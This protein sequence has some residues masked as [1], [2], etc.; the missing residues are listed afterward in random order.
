MTHQRH[1]SH[2]LS[3]TLLP[4]LLLTCLLLISIAC[5][6]PTQME[7]PTPV[8]SATATP[9]TVYDMKVE[10]L[11]RC[12]QH[13][14]KMHATFVASVQKVAPESP[15]LAMYIV[16]DADAFKRLFSFEEASTGLKESLEK[17]Y[18]ICTK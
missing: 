4:F 17:A 3:L 5:V 11:F 8:P 12:L 1:P 13:N 14:T 9:A 10:V 6:Q 15:S 16:S 7:Y 18:A 2:Q